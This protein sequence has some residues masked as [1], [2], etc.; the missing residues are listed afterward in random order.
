MAKKTV[1]LNNKKI[2]MTNFDNNESKAVFGYD[3]LNQVIDEGIKA[4]KLKPLFKNL[5][6]EQELTMLFGVTNVGKSILGIQI[7]EEIARNGEK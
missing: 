7:A 2:D 1:F 3:T 6:F 4:G 5:W